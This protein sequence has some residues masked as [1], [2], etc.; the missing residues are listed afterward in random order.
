MSIGYVGQPKDDGVIMIPD[1][2]DLADAESVNRAFRALRDNAVLMMTVGSREPIHRRINMTCDDGASVVIAPIEGAI[3]RIAVTPPGVFVNVALPTKTLTTLDVEG[4]GGFVASTA[5][6][7]YIV[8]DALGGVFKYQISPTP[9]DDARVNKATVPPNQLTR[10]LGSIVTDSAARVVKFQKSG[11][12]YL[13]DARQVLF[14]NNNSAAWVTINL[15]AGLVRMPATVR[16][17]RL[18]VQVANPATAQDEEVRLRRLGSATVDRVVY[19]PA[20]ADA[21]G[22]QGINEAEFLQPISS[23]LKFEFQ[24]KRGLAGSGG[25]TSMWITGYEE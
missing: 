10:Y 1:D 7:V 12:S 11:G 17:L 2:N 20:L 16:H 13:Y 22:V 4:G 5:Y 19:V 3:Q 24:M 8:W 9:P 21:A 6:Y 25:D 15:G 18:F 23:D 14:L